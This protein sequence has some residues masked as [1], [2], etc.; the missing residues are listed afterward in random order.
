MKGSTVTT[1]FS[2]VS[3]AA[4][5]VPLYVVGGGLCIGAMMGIDSRKK[6]VFSLSSKYHLL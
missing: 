5:A 1:L 6:K 3:N 2:V 4:F